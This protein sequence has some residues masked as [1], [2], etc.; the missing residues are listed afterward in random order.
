[1]EGK[2]P[3]EVVEYSVVFWER[4]RELQDIER[5]INQIEKGEA[6]ILRKVAV[7]K[8]LDAKVKLL[9][10]FVRFDFRKLVFC[11][12]FIISYQTFLTALKKLE[13]YFGIKAM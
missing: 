1:M 13:V 11:L 2:T 6:K 10:I 4:C 7:R 12:M 5:I 8:A 3:E 9:F